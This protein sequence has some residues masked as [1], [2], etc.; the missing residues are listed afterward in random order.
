[1]S[2]NPVLQVYVAVSPAE[3][4]ADITTPLFI[5][6][7]LEHKPIVKECN[8]LIKI[9]CQKC[10]CYSS[11]TTYSRYTCQQSSAFV[12]LMP[13]DIATKLLYNSYN[14]SCWHFSIPFNWQAQ[15]LVI[16]S[17]DL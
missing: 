9:Y 14:S 13:Q 7:G 1:M 11:A 5:S 10:L 17:I 3:L 4:P 12:F 2:S 16:L 15:N 6:L 8:L